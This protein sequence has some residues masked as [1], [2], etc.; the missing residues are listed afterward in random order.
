MKHEKSIP[1]YIDILI[2]VTICSGVLYDVI[3][4]VI[5]SSFL[6]TG[7]FEISKL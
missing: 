2:C 4:G 7:Y 5:I 1:Q 6:H 3:L